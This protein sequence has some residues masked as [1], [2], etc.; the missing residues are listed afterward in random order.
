[1]PMSMLV[2][3]HFIGVERHS[4]TLASLSHLQLSSVQA[5]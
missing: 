1:M 3:D 2:A 5:E 4:I